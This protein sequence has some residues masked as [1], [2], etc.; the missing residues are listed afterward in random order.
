M[1]N[2]LVENKLLPDGSHEPK[3]I[4]R[5]DVQYFREHP[6]ARSYVRPLMSGEFGDRAPVL[7]DNLP[8][9]MR[10]SFAV[11]VEIRHRGQG[12][13]R[14]LFRRLMLIAERR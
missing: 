1:L 4:Q 7:P 8:A 2:F 14:Q 9:G 12:H 5:G 10:C 13:P 6:Q 3:S 11:Y